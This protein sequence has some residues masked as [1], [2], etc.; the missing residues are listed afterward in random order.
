M[1]IPV[2]VI[3]VESGACAMPKSITTGSPSASMTLPGFRSLCTTPAACTAVSAAARP[4]PTVASS[5]PRSGPRSV[6]TWSS[7]RPRTYLVTMYGGSLVT[8]ASMTPATNGLRTRRIVSTSRARRRRAS[9][10]P[11]TA[12]R[13]TLTATGRCSESVAR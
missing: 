7:V 10:S 9:G 13:S 4:R 5:W 3:L 1:N 12:G 6:T 2:W 8:S 11:A